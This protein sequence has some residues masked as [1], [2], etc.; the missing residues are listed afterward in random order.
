MPTQPDPKYA[1]H[2]PSASLPNR[3]STAGHCVARNQLALAHEYWLGSSEFSAEKR[4]GILDVEGRGLHVAGAF[5]GQRRVVGLVELQ[6]PRLVGHQREGRCLRGFGA[7]VV[8][9]PAGGNIWGCF[10]SGCA[11]GGE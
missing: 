1:V 10:G 4:G 2:A 8:F 7:D 6:L 11:F 3:C 9:G 5:A